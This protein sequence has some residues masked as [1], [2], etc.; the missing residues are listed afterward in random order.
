MEFLIK[1]EV[2]DVYYLDT[3]YYLEFFERKKVLE[4]FNSII[5][6]RSSCTRVFSTIQVY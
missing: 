2:E 3:V 6:E 1:F 4:F 5:D